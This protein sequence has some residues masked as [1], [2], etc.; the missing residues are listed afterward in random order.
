MLCSSYPGSQNQIF[1]GCPFILYISCQRI[2]QSIQKQILGQVKSVFY[3]GEDHILSAGIEYQYNHLESP[4]HIDGDRASVY[5][6]TAMSSA[7]SHLEGVESGADAYITKPFSP[8]L[9]LSLV[10]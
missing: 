1:S 5:T 9:L 3:L 4:H 6:L 8:K 10:P 7:E 2:K